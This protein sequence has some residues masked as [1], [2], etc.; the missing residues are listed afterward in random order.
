MH[1]YRLQWQPGGT[2]NGSLDWYVDGER[3]YGITDNTVVR[4]EKHGRDCRPLLSLCYMV[5]RKT[6]QKMVQQHLKQTMSSRGSIGDVPFT[7][8]NREHEKH[9][10]MT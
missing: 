3:V 6:P 9:L 5:E 2:G 4:T 7:T 10:L 1:T 8:S